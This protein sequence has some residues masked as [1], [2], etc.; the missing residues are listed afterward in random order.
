MVE[1]A[2]DILVVY[3]L[4]R[5]HMYSGDWVFFSGWGDEGEA[6]ET[7][8]AADAVYFLS[9]REAREVLPALPPV[10][11]LAYEVRPCMADLTEIKKELE[12]NRETTG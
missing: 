1:I 10:L 5:P 2:D 3:V 11:A 9:D 8:D 4:R 7:G 12:A 6:T